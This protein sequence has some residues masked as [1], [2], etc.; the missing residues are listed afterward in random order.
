ML[1]NYL[2][3]LDYHIMLAYVICKRDV[4]DPSPSVFYAT[5][6]NNPELKKIP[7]NAAKG[8]IEREAI[9]RY[10]GN[11]SNEFDLAGFTIA[12]YLPWSAKQMLDLMKMTSIF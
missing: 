6:F 9:W 10:I 11:L 1:N 7:E 2:L 4:L 8:K 5:Y 12:E 3:I